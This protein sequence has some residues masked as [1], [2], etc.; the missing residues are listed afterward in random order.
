LRIYAETIK[1]RFNRLKMTSESKIGVEDE[2]WPDRI[3]KDVEPPP[4]YPLA[5][6]DLFDKVIELF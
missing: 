1:P 4:H 2:F 3:V 5:T 6:A